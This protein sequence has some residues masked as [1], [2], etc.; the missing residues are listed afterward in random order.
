[1]AL[2]E[3]EKKAQEA[4]KKEVVEKKTEAKPAEKKNV[5]ADKPVA[6]PVVKATPKKPAPKPNAKAKAK[7][8]P[9]VKVRVPQPS[10]FHSNMTDGADEVVY[11][12]NLLGHGENVHMLRAAEFYN[13][14]DDVALQKRV[15]TCGK[16][17][18]PADAAEQ[19]KIIRSLN[20]SLGN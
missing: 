8:A 20:K 11:C 9:V 15:D 4:L 12:L 17:I 6:K 10:N 7:P 14:A 13:G 1:M 18:T 19:N 2:E 16:I 5:A 3:A